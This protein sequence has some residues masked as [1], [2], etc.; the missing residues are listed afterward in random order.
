MGLLS[1]LLLEP[2]EQ[3]AVMSMMYLSR[4]E[5]NV[6][7]GS[8]FQPIFHRSGQ[9]KKK[10]AVY[11][12]KG[13]LV[14]FGAKGMEHYKDTALGLYKSS[15]HNDPERRRLYRARHSKILMKDGSPAYLNS[16]QP[17]FYSWNF[18]W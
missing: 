17:A 13:K 18:L 3:E 10:Y 5:S 16:E 6:S 1:L 11:T 7:Y 14:N 12:P 4:G 9:K 15:D 2:E 8:G